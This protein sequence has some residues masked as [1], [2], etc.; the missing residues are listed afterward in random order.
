VQPDNSTAFGVPGY[1]NFTSIGDFV[2]Y[3]T[4]SLTNLVGLPVAMAKL[5]IIPGGIAYSLGAESFTYLQVSIT[6]F[7][8]VSTPNAHH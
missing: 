7:L 1:G 5:A 6:A 2:S 8:S 4:G 3:L